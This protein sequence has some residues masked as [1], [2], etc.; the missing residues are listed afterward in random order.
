MLRAVRASSGEPIVTN[1]K[2]LFLVLL[3]IESLTN[4]AKYRKP[5]SENNET[6]ETKVLKKTKAKNLNV[7]DRS[8]LLEESANVFNSTSPWY[9]LGN[10]SGSGKLFGRYWFRVIA[11]GG[12]RIK[13]LFLRGRREIQNEVFYSFGLSGK[14]MRMGRRGMREGGE[15]ARKRKII[16]DSI[17]KRCA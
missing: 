5:R 2:P 6:T 1:A 11:L 12:D 9:V 14:G 4:K 17:R 16:G 13:S 15:S 3:Y 8:M 10:Q 7:Q